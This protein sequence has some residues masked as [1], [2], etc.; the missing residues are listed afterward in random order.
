MENKSVIINKSIIDDEVLI[1]ILDNHLVEL[2][3]FSLKMSNL[4]NG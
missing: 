3:E 4:E 1:D 2:K